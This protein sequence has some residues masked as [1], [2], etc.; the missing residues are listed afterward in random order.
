[1][2]D[3]TGLTL[4]LGY[5]RPQYLLYGVNQLI[6]LEVLCRYPVDGRQTG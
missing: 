5:L 4:N 3:S 6:P 1:M 2:G